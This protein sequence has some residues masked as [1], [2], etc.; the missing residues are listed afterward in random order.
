MYGGRAK[1]IEMAKKSAVVLV[2]IIVIIVSVKYATREEVHYDY[3]SHYD[4]LASYF[5]MEGYI[6]E[7][8]TSSG[9]RCSKNMQNGSSEFVRYDDGFTFGDRGESY[10]ISI[11]YEGGTAS[12]NG[13][14]LRT[15]NSAL[16]GYR[17]KDYT[18]TT[19]DTILSEIDKCVDQDGVVLDAGTYLGLIEKDILLLDNAIRRSGYN[20]QVLINEFKWVRLS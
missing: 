4:F 11:I 10:V 16:L 19:K 14:T 9:A 3:N 7:D 1:R 17:M 18:C 15:N 2:C 6:C 20:Y 8:L 5:T 13:I 12:R